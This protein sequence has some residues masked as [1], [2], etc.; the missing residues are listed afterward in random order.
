[1]ACSDFSSYTEFIRNGQFMDAIICPY[2]DQMGMMV[3]AM[4]VYGAISTSLY[5]YTGSI[6][7]P[8][9]LAILIGAIVMIELPA[10]AANIAVLAAVVVIAV[11]V[12]LLYRRAEGAL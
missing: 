4:L 9:V 6:I 10:I 7:I 2:A 3:F 8:L 11:G 5:I 1:M 12:Y